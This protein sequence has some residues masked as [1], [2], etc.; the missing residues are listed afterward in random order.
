MH[1]SRGTAVAMLSAAVLGGSAASAMTAAGR[2]GHGR[3]D[4]G[5][6][7][8]ATVFAATL[9]PSVPT[10]PAIHAVTPGAAPWVL[11][12]GDVALRRDGRLRLRVRG[13]VIPSFP[14]DGTPGAVTTVSA[15][16]YC[17][18]ENSPAVDTT[19][20]VPI[21]RRGDAR[22]TERL[23]LPAKCLAPVVLVHPNA[24]TTRYIA[25]GGLGG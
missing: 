4:R 8:G 1:V 19:A 13:L 20:P 3:G 6:H 16:L 21:S 17:A 15:S 2:G 18:P 14:G 24:N 5:A 9:A 23:T 11:G 25:A 7:R 22:I 12:R 10:D